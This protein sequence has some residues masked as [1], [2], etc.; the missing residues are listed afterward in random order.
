VYKHLGTR[1]AVGAAMGPEF[2]FKESMLRDDLRRLRRRVLSNPGV[3]QHQRAKL[4]QACVLS[5]LLFHI[6]AWP[7]LSAT[8]AGRFHTMIMKV[9]RCVID[10]KE[11]DGYHISDERVIKD[12]GVMPPLVVLR[13]ARVLLAVRVASRAPPFVSQLLCRAAAAPSSWLRAL[14]VDLEIFGRACADDPALAHRPLDH[15]W[16][17]FRAEPHACRR[18][19]ARAAASEAMSHVCVWAR[20]RAERELTEEHRCGECGSAFRSRQALAVHAYI[21]HGRRSEVRRSLSTTFCPICLLEFHTRERAVKHL[22][23]T[24]VCRAN[25]LLMHPALDDEC[26]RALESASADVIR[27]LRAAGRSRSFAS[28]PCVR[29]AGPLPLVMAPAGDP[30]G[31][32]HGPGRKWHASS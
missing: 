10:R 9:Y 15:W 20:T 11:D 31:H 12:L 18:R 13:L 22:D 32:P 26:F 24:A 4:A 16:S 7:G 19:F 8:L 27:E 23:S 14:E 6:G 3:P 28:L 25:L 30:K 17:L 2:A 29:L 1:T 21:L 5:R